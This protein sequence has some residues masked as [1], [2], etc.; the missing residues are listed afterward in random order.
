MH[1]PEILFYS[2]GDAVTDHA[3]QSMWH[4]SEMFTFISTSGFHTETFYIT[5]RTASNVGKSDRNTDV[6]LKGSGMCC[7]INK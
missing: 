3:I 2:C 1:Y 4:L 6:Y 5:T 7:V